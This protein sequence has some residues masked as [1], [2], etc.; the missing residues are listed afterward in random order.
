M[1]LHPLR[2][3]GR[4]LALAAGIAASALI[5][6]AC[7]SGSSTSSS[8]S[9]GGS[10]KAGGV[11]TF[12][13]P[14]GLVP[15][16]IFPFIDSAHSSIDNRNQF[17]YLMYRPLYW[18]G[19]NGQPVLNSSLSLAKPPVYSNDDKTITITLNNYRWSNGEAVT[20]KDVAF[21]LNLLAA[22]KQNWAYYVPGDLPDNLT[23][24]KIVSPTT[25]SCR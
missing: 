14:A 10:P 21:W 19:Q 25:V 16:W 1:S 23:G 17:E 8:S 24:Y 5:V 11:A 9:S 22:E 13:L 4:L 2:R 15:D 20:A 6:G 3:R 12:A 18:F 7:S